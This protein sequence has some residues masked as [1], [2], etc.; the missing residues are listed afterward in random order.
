MSP[1]G[2]T[3]P[4]LTVTSA[5]TYDLQLTDFC[6]NVYNESIVVT[7]DLPVAS[8]TTVSGGSIYIFTN[9]STNATSYS[10]DFGDG[11]TST[12]TNPTHTYA[13]TSST[14][15][16]TLIATNACGTHTETFT[17]VTVDVPENLEARGLN[18]YPNPV[19]ENL[20]LD[21]GLLIGED[22]SID[23]FD[24][25]GRVLISDQ[26]NGQSGA[27]QKTINV[28]GLTDGIYFV[29][30]STIDEVVTKKIIKN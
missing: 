5:G 25:Q 10:W 27:Y 2:A 29:R 11:N 20:T 15:T 22:I 7:E 21:F 1:G 30:L 3:T 18:I 8:F 26:I 19:N 24:I 28:N 13:S 9:T 4:T 23:I 6:G 12:A 16:V 14:Y 17:A